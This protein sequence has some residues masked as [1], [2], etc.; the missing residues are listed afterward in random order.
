MTNLDISGSSQTRSVNPN[1]S[2][3]GGGRGTRYPNQF[4]DLSQ[5]YMPPT[6]KELFRWCTFYFYNSPL[7]GSSIKKISRYPI[8]DLIFEDELD[9]VRDVWRTILVD[10]LKLKDRLME[11]NLD[12]H[13]Y[14]NAFVSI[15]LPF[16]R[17]LICQGCKY[18]QPIRQWDW[19]FNG[20]DYHFTGVCAE[21]N[22]RGAVDV[23]DVP[24]KDRK[25][26]R[27]IRWNPENIHIKFNDYTGRYIYMYSVPGKLR[28][29]IQRGDKDVLEDIP[30]VVLDALKKRRLIRL[31]DRAIKHLK[32]P[33]LAE[34]D[35]GWGKP[36]IIHVL[37]DM[38]YFYTLRRAQEAIALEH[39]VPF[40]IIY[41]MPNAQQDPYIHTDLA[42][43]KV[44]I[45]D[46]I[47]RHR[48]DPNFK[49]VIPIPVGFGRIGGDGK[50]LLLS[51]EL[52]YLTQTIVGGM[53]IPQ[54][55]LFGGL[56]FCSIKST[57]CMTSKGLLRLE[58]LCPEEPG[59]A[60]ADFSVLTKDG[61]E[62]VALTH[63]TAKRKQVKIK[64]R[65]GLTLTG[66]PV[67]KVWTIDGEVEMGWK[68]LQNFKP[69]E[70][71]A[72]KKQTGL[73]GDRAVN[74]NLCRLLGYLV[75]EGS[76]TEKCTDF[77]NTD[78]AILEDY[79]DC[80]E[81]TFG[82]RPALQWRDF[83]ESGGNH[84]YAQVQCRDSAVTAELKTLD[85]QHYSHTKRVPRLIREGTKAS[86]AAFLSALFSGDGCIVDRDK[87]QTIHYN[88]VSER[89]IEEVQ[90]LLM[91]FGILSTRYPPYTGECAESFS[92]LNNNTHSLQIRSEYVSLFMKEIGFT[93]ER[94]NRL[95]REV[96]DRQGFR[97]EANKIPY[98]MDN[99]KAL[100]KLQN[101]FGAWIKEHRQ[102]D[103]QK[104]LYTTAEVAD[105]LDRDV[106]SVILYIRKGKLVA[107]KEARNDGRYPSWL[108]T[109]PALEAFLENYGT[110][111]RAALGQ[112]TWE[113]TDNNYE[114][115]NWEGVKAL[116]PV[117]Y[118]RV[119]EAKKADHWWDQIEEVTFS[120]EEVE[121]CDLTVFNTHSYVA[122]GIISHN[123][124]SSISLR[125][126]ENDFIQNRSQ[127]LDLVF[128][129]KE[130]IRVWLDIPDVKRVRFADFRMADD[131][132]RNQQVVGLNASGKLSDHTMLT[133]LG[134]D[135][136]QE[137]K[138]KIEELFI[139]N[140]ISDLQTKGAAKAQGEAS[141]VQFN[142]QSKVQELAQKAQI[143]AQK[144]MQQ[145]IAKGE[146][147]PEMFQQGQVGPDGQ[148]LPGAT[149]DAGA[150]GG[151]Q[152]Q[153]PGGMPG[154]VQQ[155]A[156]GGAGG[157]PA[158]GAPAAGGK[159]PPQPDMVQQRL[160]RWTSQ[161]IKMDPG[162]ANLTITDIKVKMPDVGQ[163]LERLYKMKMAEMGGSGGVSTAP[164][165]DAMPQGRV[166]AQRMEM[167]GARPMTGAS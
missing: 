85:M 62:R 6:I 5:Q 102:H 71:V 93:T 35:Q 20:G 83:S 92:G 94:K 29:M 121:M 65:S 33:T 9:S 72:L 147:T 75:A 167:V 74:P 130:K 21:C 103:L 144:K 145:M 105:I 25:S 123:T 15:H 54:E 59:I 4:F 67:H 41:P 99:L 139:Q 166:G 51:P 36:T 11:V 156:Q 48:A 119:A 16:T 107:E 56:N 100:R 55:F 14:G 120:D 129:I 84:P 79:L 10:E 106:S 148:P 111:K 77:G 64:M 140:Y 42:D 63:H 45:E 61:V 53:G 157:P 162:Q 151:G 17:F 81:G 2:I 69:G 28:S 136:E 30:L 82:K 49:A 89:L 128:W 165:M 7:I 98:V 104:D 76:V 43:W 52:N 115:V 57:L 150:P 164:N 114:L 124:G 38:F 138:K 158:P 127:L 96:A 34:Q 137:T 95:Y 40:D 108:I 143:S 126:L 118:D 44:K 39:I 86:V 13:V 109:K 66:S 58:E 141:L 161:L 24:Y 132:Q 163:Q 91:N 1:I 116:D 31:D 142:Y 149:P 22:K 80:F 32:N 131:V 133:E 155:A 113:L 3:G 112:T 97:C 117:L 146:A 23:K 90:L 12:Y 60:E 125:T 73:W 134:F 78:K 159:G 19:S 101:G 26:I 153:D 160:E 154:N 37:K 47:T 87:K 88:S 70:Y 18:R 46:I 135:Y 152:G 68:A 8:T 27:L 122:N 50:A 110:Q